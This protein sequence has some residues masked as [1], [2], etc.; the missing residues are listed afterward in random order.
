MFPRL[1]GENTVSPVSA[2]GLMM[3]WALALQV[4]GL[5]GQHEP[6]VVQPSAHYTKQ[7]Y[8]TAARCQKNLRHALDK[9]VSPMRTVNEK[10]KRLTMA[11]K[12]WPISC[13]TTCHSVR[14]AVETAVTETTEV[15]PPEASCWQL[16]D[17]DEKGIIPR[18]VL[19]SSQCC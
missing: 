1:Q 18:G 13:A 9:R 2:T 12:L 7:I 8:G 14:P 17:A 4:E 3:N 6:D 10:N 15:T 11:P 16:V 19:V 5:N